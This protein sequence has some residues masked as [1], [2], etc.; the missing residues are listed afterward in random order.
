MMDLAVILQALASC[1]VD[2]SIEQLLLKQRVRASEHPVLLVA[3]DEPG[4]PLDLLEGLGIAQVTPGGAPLSYPV[5][6]SFGE[7]FQVIAT[8]AKGEKHHYFDMTSFQTYCAEKIVSLTITVD[9]PILASADIR[10]VTVTID[11]TPKL[12]ELAGD[13]IGV[14]LAL[15]STAGAPE[16]AVDELCK[17]LKNT[18]GMADKVCLLLNHAE[19]GA[20]NEMLEMMLDVEPLS[21]WTCSYQAG[22]GDSPQAALTAALRAV[23]DV[24]GSRGIEELTVQCV[25]SAR[26]KLD[27][28]MEEL[29]QAAESKDAAAIWF[30]GNSRDFRAKMQM[31]GATL[32]IRLSDSQRE[33]LYSDIKGLKQQLLLELP[34]MGRELVEKKDKQAKEDMNNLAGLYIETLCNSYMDFVTGQI[35]DN[36]LLPQAKKAYQEAADDYASLVGRAPVP[37]EEWNVDQD[38]DLL[39]SIQINLGNFHTA[40]SKVVGMFAG[41][42]LRKAFKF[43]FKDFGGYMRGF[44]GQLEDKIKKAVPDLIDSILPPQS[45]VDQYIKNMRQELDRIPGMMYTALDETIIPQ[46]SADMSELFQEMVDRRIALLEAQGNALKKEAEEIR[47][48]RTALAENSKGLAA[49]LE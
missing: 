40:I 13:C 17:W 22:A 26:D 23:S 42:A 10:F 38:A 33:E 32:S 44:T 5:Q 35:I 47:S 27:K 8:D 12:G 3:G 25:E 1:G 11:T 30:F 46:I 43:I 21:T 29:E 34:E 31:A 36:I 39:K 18:S 49:L 16:P 41:V 15:D 9:T 14:L 19:S 2:T 6:C 24:E 7:K 28:R 4:R 37:M 45:Y 20:V 48:K